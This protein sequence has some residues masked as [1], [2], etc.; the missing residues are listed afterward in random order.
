MRVQNLSPREAGRSLLSGLP[1]PHLRELA[2]GSPLG[3]VEVPVPYLHPR[4][5]QPKEELLHQQWGRGDTPE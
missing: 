4:L 1:P 3:D 2:A 5:G